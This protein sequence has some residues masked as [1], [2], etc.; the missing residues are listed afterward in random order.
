M[1]LVPRKHKCGGMLDSSLCILLGSDN[2]PPPPFYK[3]VIVV[4]M[5]ASVPKKYQIYITFD[6]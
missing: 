4:K 5:N 2:S 1:E 6:T 3:D